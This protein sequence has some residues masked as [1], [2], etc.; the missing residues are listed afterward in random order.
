[1]L[2]TGHEADGALDAVEL[3]D[4]AIRKYEEEKE[5][6]KKK[7]AEQEAMEGE[8]GEDPFSEGFEG[9]DAWESGEPGEAAQ[10]SSVQE[11]MD[12]AVS[13]F[14]GEPAAQG[15]GADGVGKDKDERGTGQLDVEG[16]DAPRSRILHTGASARARC[17]LTV[18]LARLLE[19]SPGVERR[20][21]GKH[22]ARFPSALDAEEGVDDLTDEDEEGGHFDSESESDSD[23]DLGSESGSDSGSES[24]SET[25]P[26]R[27]RARVA[28]PGSG[29]G[30]GAATGAGAGAG[31][32]NPLTLFG[33]GTSF[34]AQDEVPLFGE[35]EVEV[36]HGS[37][38]GA[39]SSKSKSK[40]KS[41]DFFESDAASGIS[42]R[43]ARASALKGVSRG[44][45]RAVCE[46]LD[47]WGPSR[48][49]AEVR[50]VCLGTHDEDG[51]ALLLAL[52]LV[53]L[54]RV[55]RMARFDLAQAQL[56]LALR[57]HADVIGSTS[58]LR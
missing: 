38:S 14:T 20:L 12:K 31:P 56:G 52:L 13:F 47:S 58:S 2:P 43:K 53:M 55:G 45:I 54:W 19:A 5:A 17:S 18:A 11:D 21:T 6:A 3:Q 32:L 39:A 23:S 50:M 44:A 34:D 15:S 4:E 57:A 28:G 42:W 7:A 26:G 29:S 25:G 37:V 46:M 24:D 1:M 48:V 8:G 51:Q 49:D 22:V 16:E 10:G 27:K 41:G 30:A 9:A 33:A 40:S 36:S 35:V